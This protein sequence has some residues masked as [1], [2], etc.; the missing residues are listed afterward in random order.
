MHACMCVPFIRAC[1]CPCVCVPNPETG[2][3]VS[4]DHERPAFVYVGN[5]HGDETVGRELLQQLVI[6]LAPADSLRTKTILS[7]AVIYVI[8]TMNPDGFAAM[9]RENSNGVDLNRNFPDS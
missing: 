6:F 4:V 5:M 2:D 3:D 1:A 7:S 9:R 8:P